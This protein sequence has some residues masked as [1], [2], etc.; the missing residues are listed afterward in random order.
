MDTICYM[1]VFAENSDFIRKEKGMSIQALADDC[2]TNRSN[3]SKILN[4]KQSPS[5]VTMQKM[6]AAL[7]SPLHDLLNPDFLKIA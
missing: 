5:L 3:M 2:G 1:E 6:A 7:D 4:G